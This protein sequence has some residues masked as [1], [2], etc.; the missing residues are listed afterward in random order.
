M[1]A[2]LPGIMDHFAKMPNSTQKTADILKVFGRNGMA[3]LPFLNRGSEGLAKFSEEAEKNG[4]ILSQS[5]LDAVTKNT[6]AQREFHS[7]LEGLQVQIGMKLY[8]IMT[9]MTQ[10]FL[11]QWPTIR[12]QLEPAMKMLGTAAQTLGNVVQTIVLPAISGLG[13]WLQKYSGWI[14]PIVGSIGAMVIAWKTYTMI[15][16]A[17]RIAME[18]YKAG[19]I[20]FIA[21]T[22]GMEAAQIGL[23]F[24][25]EG[26]TVSTGAMTAAQ[27]L[28]N[29]AM[30]AN[31]IG[32]IVLALVALTA[33][34]VIAYK[35]SETFRR[36]VTGAF[37]SIKAA[38]GNIWDGMSEAAGKVFDVI[39][40]LVKGYIN[41]WIGLINYVIGALNKIHFKIPDIKGVPDRGK[42]VGIN[43]AQIPYLAS[44]GI[45]SSPTLAMIGEAGPE[46]V[47]PLSRLNGG[48]MSSQPMIVNIH[49]AGSVVQENDLAV[50]VRDSI[51]Q[52]MRRT[53]NNPSILGV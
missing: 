23:T 51:A 47:V 45:V 46:A 3:I 6:M 17:A 33:G 24:A 30:D 35:H 22:S 16:T 29:A 28:L 12:T 50:K 9:Q 41:I 36:I 11:K 1:D 42:E 10:A 44:G 32:L 5:N 18:L 2:V 26:G 4:L 38:F 43:I 25:T 20:I 13:Q 27:W 8:P 40:K 39:G 52:M 19:Q 48:A 34:F 7:A 37:K 21:L 15:Q 31:P 14:I 49:V 53:G